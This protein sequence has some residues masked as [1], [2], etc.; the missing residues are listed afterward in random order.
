MPTVY[1]ITRLNNALGKLWLQLLPFHWQREK[2][3][4]Y[5]IAPPFTR[6]LYTYLMYI[7]NIV[8][9][10]TEIGYVTPNKFSSYIYVQLAA[11]FYKNALY[12]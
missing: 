5:L 7:I 6:F 4:F 10:T 1:V 3:H 11:F 9:F 12:G 2:S 8:R